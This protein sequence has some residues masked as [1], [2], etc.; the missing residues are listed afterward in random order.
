MTLEVVG[1]GLHWLSGPLNQSRR[2]AVLGSRSLASG[3][4][5]RPAVSSSPVRLD[6]QSG[7][8]T[9]VR[10]DRSVRSVPLAPVMPSGSS[11]KRVT[12]SGTIFPRALTDGIS[13][14]MGPAHTPGELINGG[15]PRAVVAPPALEVVVRP[16]VAGG[17]R[18]S[19]C[20]EGCSGGT[21]FSPV[22]QSTQG[23]A[24]S[25]PRPLEMRPATSRTGDR[26]AASHNALRSRF[27][28]AFGLCLEPCP[29]CASRSPW[30]PERGR[31]LL[32][33]A[34]C[35]AVVLRDSPFGV[36]QAVRWASGP[37]CRLGSAGFQP[38]RQGAIG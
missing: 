15:S 34:R 4:I 24:R 31:A 38:A 22:P 30:W 5:G 32:R 11:E 6:W 17:A 37:G 27:T 26:P 35:L 20:H 9:G 28:S 21:S 8:L 33:R 16:D 29:L 12:L 10:A 3:L 2:E 7:Q 25:A 19:E 1:F 13:R 18:N 14:H 23:P 36:C